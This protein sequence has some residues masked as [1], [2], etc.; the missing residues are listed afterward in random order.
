MNSPYQFF[1]FIIGFSLFLPGFF[2]FASSNTVLTLEILGTPPEIE[3]LQL[4][5]ETFGTSLAR[6]D[7][8]EGGTARVY[9]HGRASMSTTCEAIN[10]AENYLVTLYYDDLDAECE[11]DGVFCQQI[12]PELV[13]F[14]SCED[15]SDLDIDFS[16]P[17]DIPFYTYASDEGS[18]NPDALWHLSLRVIADDG[19]AD[20][21]VINFEVASLI[22]F[23]TNTTVNYGSVSKGK[24]SDAETITFTQ[25]GNTGVETGISFSEIICETGSIGGENIE[26]SLVPGFS[27]GSG[28]TLDTLQTLW[29]DGTGEAFDIQLTPQTQALT[30]TQ[31]LVRTRLRMPSETIKGACLG[32]I[33]F[34]ATPHED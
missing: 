33:T 7:L 26:L 34:T 11:D 9:A 21:E 29:N 10:D 30:P 16:V 28:F 18:T 5:Q 12:D 32:S 24:S 15:P 13:H 25:K 17:L 14:S 1:I 20:E 8:Q 4:S 31:S 19:G 22:A 3:N 6:V 23:D 27:F 2:A